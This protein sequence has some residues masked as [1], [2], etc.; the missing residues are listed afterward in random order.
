MTAF[1]DLSQRISPRLKLVD[2]II[3]RAELYKLI[4]VRGTPACGK[5]VLVDLVANELL[6]K[7]EWPVFVL[8]G[9]TRWDVESVGWHEYLRKKTGISGSD[10]P[11]TKAYLLFDEAQESYWDGTMWASLF[12][13]MIPFFDDCPKIILFASYGFPGRGNAGFDPAKFFKT[14]VEFGPSQVIAMRSEDSLDDDEKLDKIGI[15]LN[16]AEASDMMD[17]CGHTGGFLLAPDLRERFYHIS[18][19]HAGC[20]AALIGVLGRTPVSMND[21]NTIRR[22]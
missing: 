13:T 12:K 17:R 7:T 9:W 15:L 6:R 18:G 5:S 21:K 3:E 8:N 16:E 14:P 10:W 4:I 20:L 22:S 19:G 2:G 11:T 1:T